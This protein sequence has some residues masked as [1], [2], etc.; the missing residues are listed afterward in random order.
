MEI[1]SPSYLSDCLEIRRS[2]HKMEKKKDSIPNQMRIYYLKGKTHLN[3]MLNALPWGPG[4]FQHF[5]LP[6]TLLDFSI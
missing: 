5:P 2:L 4:R 1:S 6:P 3:L